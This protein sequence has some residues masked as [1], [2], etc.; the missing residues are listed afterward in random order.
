VHFFLEE[1]EHRMGDCPVHREWFRRLFGP[2]FIE[3]HAQR[4]PACA[5]TTFGDMAGIR[6]YLDLMVTVTMQA[7]ELDKLFGGDQGVHNYILLQKLLNNVAV[8]ENGSGPVLT[9]KKMKESD[10]Q[11]DAQGAVLIGDGVLVPVLHQY[12][13]FPALKARLMSSLE[14]A[15]RIA[16]SDAVPSAVRAGDGAPA[17]QS[18][19]AIN[20]PG[21]DRSAPRELNPQPLASEANALSS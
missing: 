12:D 16:V 13:C 7:V 14:T 21:E 18:S 3:S 1:P 19:P 2:S 20:A 4:I 5:G 6:Q 8:H 15:G 9:M 17:R 11:V 10:W